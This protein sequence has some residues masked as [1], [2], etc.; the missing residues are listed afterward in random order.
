MKEKG[1]VGWGSRERH[2]EA[3]YTVTEIEGQIDRDRGM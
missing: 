3:H 1:E 2:K